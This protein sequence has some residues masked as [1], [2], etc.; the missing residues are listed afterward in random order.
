MYSGQWRE[1]PMNQVN[2]DSRVEQI[3]IVVATE[4]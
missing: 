3:Q 2:K 1:A 4:H